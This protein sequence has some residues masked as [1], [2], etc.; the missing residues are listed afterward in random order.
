MGVLL[1]L[2]CMVGL[3]GEGSYLR[4]MFKK[5]EANEAVNPGYTEVPEPLHVKPPEAI[6]E[7]DL[8]LADE[9]QPVMEGELAHM[10]GKDDEVLPGYDEAAP[11]NGAWSARGEEE[12]ELPTDADADTDDAMAAK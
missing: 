6:D 4:E 3:F 9:P 11:V 12:S 1:T 5:K 8:E 2:S 7:S 10:P